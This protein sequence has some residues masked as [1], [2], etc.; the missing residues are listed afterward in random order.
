V[1]RVFAAHVVLGRFMRPARRAMAYMGG[2][3][4]RTSLLACGPELEH[5]VHPGHPPHHGHNAVVPLARSAGQHLAHRLLQRPLVVGPEQP[6]GDPPVSAQEV[7]GVGLG[8]ERPVQLALEAVDQH[9]PGD[10][11]ALPVAAGVFDLLFHGCRLR[12]A[13]AVAARR[14]RLA[15]ADHL[16]RQQAPAAHLRQDVAPQRRTGG[17]AVDQDDREALARLGPAHRHPTDCRLLALH[18]SSFV[19]CAAW[20]GA[21]PGTR[22]VGTVNQLAFGARR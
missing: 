4:R 19:R 21:R 17:D 22:P 11:I 8:V 7:D 12:V 5:F 2:A 6:V 9:R 14:D 10:A 18:A 15:I 16:E 13:V 1:G 20:T 3:S